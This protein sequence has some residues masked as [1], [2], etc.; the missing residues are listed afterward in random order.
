MYKSV[1]ES[2]FW[3]AACQYVALNTPVVAAITSLRSDSACLSDAVLYATRI[4][5]TLHELEY[6]QESTLFNSVLHIHELQKLWSK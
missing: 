1:L 6:S 2:C 5:K 3:G 4:S